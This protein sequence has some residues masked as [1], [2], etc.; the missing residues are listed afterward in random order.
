MRTRCRQP[1]LATSFAP[2][3]T[4]MVMTTMT[5]GTTTRSRLKRV[6]R[7]MLKRWGRPGPTGV[8]L[9]RIRV[10]KS[11]YDRKLTERLKDMVLGL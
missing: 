1:T 9:K 5:R 2:T 3:I 6:T 4:M 11:L 8:R 7:S 10:D